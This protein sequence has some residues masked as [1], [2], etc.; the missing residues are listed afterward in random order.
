MIFDYQQVDK[1]EHYMKNGSDLFANVGASCC[2]EDNSLNINNN[3]QN[4]EINQLSTDNNN[5]NNLE[6]VD[7]DNDNMIMIMTYLGLQQLIIKSLSKSAIII[8]SSAISMRKV[9]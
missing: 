8:S 7:N 9:L 3:N 2:L 1:I 4:T 6:D 5:N